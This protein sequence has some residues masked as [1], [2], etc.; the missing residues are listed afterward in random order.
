MKRT[1]FRQRARLRA[2]KPLRRTTP[3]QRTASMAASDAQRAAVAGRSC[4]VCGSEK[5]VDPAHLIPRSLGGCG[6]ALCVTALCRRCHR[7]YDRGE[8]DLLPYLEPA[9][10]AQLAHAV[11][12]VGL[13]GVLRRITAT[14]GQAGGVS[15][16][17]VS[18]RPASE[19]TSSTE[20]GDSLWGRNERIRLAELEADSRRPMGELLEEGVE[21]SRV[22]SELASTAHRER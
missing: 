21:L 13:I 16:A 18:E 14:R 10:R 3:L 15:F 9:W 2:R 17:G 12:H 8:L 11:G 4:I 5:R 22:A 6:H 19:P 20:D 7:A 1:S